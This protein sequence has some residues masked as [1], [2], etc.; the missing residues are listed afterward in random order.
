MVSFEIAN[1]FCS[2]NGAS[3]ALEGN[4]DSNGLFHRDKSRNYTRNLVDDGN[5]KY[6]NLMIL[7]WNEGKSSPIHDHAGAHC[8]MKVLAGELTETQYDWPRSKS[9]G[10]LISPTSDSET[11]PCD[12]S[13]PTLPRMT[14][15]KETALGRNQATYIHGRFCLGFVIVR[16]SMFV[17]RCHDR[18]NWIAS[19]WESY[20]QTCNFPA[21]V[22]P[23]L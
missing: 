15:K 14:V 16:S 20:F 3:V 6:F 11:E 10:G 7:C 13:V 9:T 5:G 19:R 18:Q 1:L 12:Q 17:S 21:F 8:I 4:W 22:Y 2:L 23:G